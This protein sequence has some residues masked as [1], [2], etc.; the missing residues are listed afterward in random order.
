MRYGIPYMGSKSKFAPELIGFLPSGKRFVDLF[1]GGFAMSHCAL[2]S[3]KYDRVVYSDIEPL[4]VELVKEA[5]DGKYNYKRFKPKFVSREQFHAMKNSSGY[6]RY[7]WSFGNNGQNYLFGTDVEPIKKLA[8]D[9]LIFGDDKI[10]RWFPNI[11]EAVTSDDLIKRRL[12]FKRYIEKN[13]PKFKK[14]ELERIIQLERLQQLQQLEMLQ[15]SYFDYEYQNGDVVYCDIPYE[16][17]ADYGSTFNHKEF[18]DWAYSR[19]YQVWF[20]SY[21]NISDSRFF[22]VWE[23]EVKSTLSATNN[24]CVELECLYTNKDNDNNCGQLSLF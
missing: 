23:K 21:D 13:E 11:D 15:R 22:Q 1:G 10:K 19:P 5:I 17:T 4:V 2:L 18:Y 14:D 24:N 20:S 8:H 9:Y 16:G 3:Q 6:I 7:I 12:Q